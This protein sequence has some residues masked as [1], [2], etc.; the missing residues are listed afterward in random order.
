MNL[1]YSVNN[2]NFK[3]GTVIIAGAGPGNIKLVTINT[4]LALKSADVVIYDSL[5]NKAL[6]EY[7]KKNVK[8]IFAGKT[9]TNRACSQEDINEWLVKYA[10]KS[11]KVLRLKGGDISFFSRGSQEITYLK[12][13]K[14]KFKIFTG[15]TSAQAALKEVKEKSSNTKLCLNFITGHKKIKTYSRQINY[16]YLVNTE[17]RILIYMGVSQIESIRNSLI[18]NGMKKNTK[19]SIISNASL[20]NQIIYNTNLKD[21][22]NFI[23][24]NEVKPPSI[25]IIK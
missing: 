14:V 17:G 12:K 4:I 11:K 25:I 5:I 8:L 21:I 9:S 15:I 16:D 19:I 1:N 10:K 23:K 22:N 3:E 20:E 7:C 24:N 2:I 18:K 13:N 6:L